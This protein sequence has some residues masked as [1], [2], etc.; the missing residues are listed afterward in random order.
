MFP[1]AAFRLPFFNPDLECSLAN[2]LFQFRCR[3]S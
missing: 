3:A 2:A 1:I